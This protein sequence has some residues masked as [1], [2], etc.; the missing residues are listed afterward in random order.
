M[1]AVLN[2]GARSLALGNSLEA[3]H[4]FAPGSVAGNEVVGCGLPVHIREASKS[5][6]VAGLK[7]ELNSC[8]CPLLA[9]PTIPFHFGGWFF[10]L[11][12]EAVNRGP[13]EEAQ[14][15][16]AARLGDVGCPPVAKTIGPGHSG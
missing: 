16:G 8:P 10:S 11:E 3:I 9:G 14:L 1:P 13:I 6:G 5:S 7:A 2:R 12:P 4:Q 15:D